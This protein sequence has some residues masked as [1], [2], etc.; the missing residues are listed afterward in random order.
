LTGKAGQ[1]VLYQITVHNTGNVPLTLSNLSDATCMN[2]AGGPGLAELAPGASTAYSCERALAKTST[3][4]NEASVE[5]IPPADD[6][7]PLMRMSN[8]VI[9]YGPSPAPKIQTGGA[10]EV[11]QRVAL[12]NA[13]V[14]PSGSE[15]TSCK[16][17]YGTTT[18]YGSS[19]SCSKL[20]GFGSSAVAVSASLKGLSPSTTY[21]FRIS[22]TSLSGTS[23]GA[24][25]ELKTMVAAAP[26]AQTAGASEVGQRTALLSA[27]V[28]PN[29]GEVTSCKFEYGTTTSYGSSVP[30]SK[31]PGLGTS[32]VAV[33]AALK[34]LS[35]NTTYH[36][37]ISA[38]SLSGTSKGTEATFKTT[39]AFAPTVETGSAS[40]VGQHTAVLNATV[41]PNGGEVTSCKFEYGTTTS[42]GSSVPCSKLPGLG[43]STVAVSA[44]LKALSPN[45]TYHFRISATSLSGTS[46]GT[47]ATFKT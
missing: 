24:D 10:S 47:G 20:P 41:N 38:T 27:T 26:T 36:F 16:F 40:E 23:K 7:F 6:G 28:N 25:A 35:P 19:V 43:T 8:V 12:L 29:G 32:T 17:E 13:T 22:A 4:V 21:H 33:S 44:A 46:K 15:V 1:T 5:G 34:A 9:A 39:V 14:N 18:S 37:R 31:L 42:Y 3:F 30:C 45:T 11:G 2:I